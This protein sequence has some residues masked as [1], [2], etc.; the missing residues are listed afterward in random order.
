MKVLTPN[1]TNQREICAD[2]LGLIAQA[3]ETDIVAKH[4]KG[5]VLANEDLSDCSFKACV[6]ENCRLTDCRFLNT[7]FTDVEFISCDFSGSDFSQG[8]FCRC[9]ISSCKGVGVN[10]LDAC[11]KQLS[12]HDSN[13]MY[14]NLGKTTMKNCAVSESDLSCARF[15]ECTQAQVTLSKV[16]L[17]G[18][19]FFTTPLKDL[20]FS[21]SQIDG[22]IVSESGQELKGA[23]VSPYQAS[24][25]AKLLG[26][27]IKD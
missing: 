21:D 2:L 16:R 12:L 7:D 24:E 1:L 26:V 23:V 6:F 9:R 19:S 10:M 27:R 25:L 4:I 8:Y 17:T 15:C 20:D 11:L 18:A 13:F 14:M 22:L 5:A 3:D